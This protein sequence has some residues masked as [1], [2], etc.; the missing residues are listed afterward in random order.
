LN[1]STGTFSY[2]YFHLLCRCTFFVAIYTAR[3][4]VAFWLMLLHFQFA[5]S[6][7]K[8]MTVR[9]QLGC[10]L[11]LSSLNYLNFVLLLVIW[12]KIFILRNTTCQLHILSHISFFL[13]FFLFCRQISRGQTISC[14]RWEQTS[15]TNTQRVGSEIWT[16]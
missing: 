12:T 2:Q 9:M 1:T 14:L 3:R 4:P 8:F 13:S 15:N 5:Y 16:N 6:V 7:L 10:S 11:L